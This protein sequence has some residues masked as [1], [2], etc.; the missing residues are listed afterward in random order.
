MV[1][2]TRLRLSGFKSFVDPTDL[3][4]ESGLT[5]VVGPNG[6]GKSNLVEALR[7]VMG[8]TSAKQMRGGEMDD[9]IFG[10]T[11]QRPARN[12]AEVT[13]DLDNS[14]GT[15]T[16]FRQFQDLEITRRIERGSGSAYR[17]NGKDARARDVQ[18]L[19]ADA[20]TGARS[21]AMVSQGRVGAIIAA[22]PAQRR[23]LLEEAAGI[24]G[25]HARR[26]EAELRLKGAEANLERLDD[27]L[28]ALDGQARNLR[29][30]ARQAAQYREISEAIRRAEAVVMRQR[31]LGAIRGLDRARGALRESERLV[32]EAT[33][34]ATA[35][36]TAHERAAEALPPLRERATEA[37]AALQRLVVERERLEAERKRVTAALADNRTRLEQTDRDRERERTRV[38]DAEAA[39]ARL[40]QE[41]TALQAAAEGETA[42]REAT[43]AR[44]QA[45]NAE[46]NAREA[47]A[48]RATQAL[49]EADARRSALDRRVAEA[50]QRAER[51]S[52]RRDDLTRELETAR[53]RALDPAEVE[54]AEAAVAK[55][56]EARAD[57]GARREQAEAA[58]IEARAA[59][60]AA[61]EAAQGVAAERAS[62]RA[63]VQ[64]LEQMLT[65]EAPPA[66]N[67]PP[68]LESLTAAPGYET[69][70]GAAL[71]DDLTAALDAAAPAF[72]ADLPP[73]AEATPL[74]PG[75]VPL[76]D[77]VRA[78]PALARA[79]A[80]VGVVRDRETGDAL[81][82]D[83]GP[84]QR[85]VSADGDLWRWDGLTARAGA[86]AGAAAGAQAAARLRTRNRLAEL[87][88][89]LAAAEAR[90]ADAETAVQAARDGLTQAE[91]AERAARDGVKAADGALSQARAT[92]EALRRKATEAEAK[93]ASVKATLDQV[94]ADGTEAAAQV[95]AARAERAEAGDGA[96]ARAALETQRTALTA[97]RTA[98]VEARAD[99]D[100]LL[101]EIG[102]RERRTKAVADDLASWGR[103]LEQG[104]ATL[105]DLDARRAEITAALADL[106]QAPEAL[107]AQQEA[108]ADSIRAA[109]AAQ[110]EAADTLAQAETGARE[111]DA[112]RKAADGALAQA[113]ETRVRRDSEVEQGQAACRSVAGDIADRLDCTPDALPETAGLDPDDAL[114]DLEAA[115]A[116]LSRLS[117]Q[118]DGIGPVNLRA[119]AELAEL[120]E[121]VAALRHERE[122]LTG[123]IAR[124]RQ[125]ISEIN[126]EGRQ[127]LVDSF[128]AVNEH[129]RT[130]FTRLYG[131]GQAH[132]E[133]IES[134]DPLEAGLEI[135]ASPPGKRLQILSLLSGGEQALTALALL[136]AV[137]LTNPAPICVL[138]E[139]DAPLDDANVDRLCTLL[140][141]LTRT[142]ATRFLMVTHHRMTMAR[143]DRLFGV[144]MMERGVS[145][146]VSVDLREAEILR[147]QKP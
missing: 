36:T 76:A 54:A 24:S 13:I 134:N 4:I 42:A 117:R 52:R 125:G 98:L 72:W 49:A 100:R 104:R 35:A 53:A 121:K 142:T 129:F 113:R 130:L 77:H 17:V 60:D 116:D 95:E 140:E 73:L 83:L 74:P 63:E 22:K 16:A 136:F 28:S 109:E 70:L 55:A 25:L 96:E 12:I 62:L 86:G 89:A 137:F 26:H 5:G 69:A 51:L 78:P 45:V 48:T 102:D 99:H 85:L 11:S 81:R 133:M 93:L 46:V 144:T 40:T 141:D 143:M 131:G 34:A 9:V 88:E 147:D 146:L 43:T 66:G 65:R 94:T 127:R 92:A 21:T 2:F 27:V 10:G 110:A 128:T 37:A 79:L 20:A 64:A 33:A 68:V 119:E 8:E 47:E 18:L 61:R 106:E 115:E 139:V 120:D 105:A 14:D 29:K 91:T 44:L 126:R 75:V 6:C 50:A 122:D 58:R 97:Q 80:A 145:K 132:L 107:R 3:V 84:G 30:Q 7:W 112:A 67:A 57:A 1:Q 32:G 15:A 114:P 138:D 123:A 38:T 87:S 71:G 19:F 111:A 108:L 41:Q 39:L 82:H 90:V 135:M 23:A 59:F 124:L 103:R 31:W 101:R 118:R 56:E